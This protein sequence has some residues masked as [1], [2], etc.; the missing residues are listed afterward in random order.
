[1]T[2]L[3]A[4]W[5]WLAPAVVCVGMLTA[6]LG[7]RHCAATQAREQA[8]AAQR[9]RDEL[10]KATGRAEAREGVADALGALA[11]P[12]LDAGVQAAQRAT[13]A[14]KHEAELLDAGMGD[15]VP[16]ILEDLRGV[17]DVR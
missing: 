4:N 5:R 3:I 13:E 10:N 2:W 9:A 17:W 11:A 7:A 15:T 8:E 6:A 12:L 16:D 1:M 14:V